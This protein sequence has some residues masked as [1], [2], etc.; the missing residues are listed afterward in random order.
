MA[1]NLLHSSWTDLDQV[2]LRILLR[3][4]IGQPGQF[5]GNTDVLYL[6][7]AREKCRVSLTYKGSRII[8]IEPGEAFDRPEWDRICAEIET[9]ILSG[10]RKVG[11]E[12]SFNTFR[13]GGS[14]RGARSGV[15]ILPPPDQAPQTPMEITDHPF[16]LEFPIQEAGLWSI[17][18]H[19][20][21]REHRKLTLLLN[22]LLVGTTKFLPERPR[23]LWACVGFG[24]E[25]EIKWVQEWYF[26]KLSEAI[27]NEL[28]P[29]T[30]E[31]LEE[32]SH[33]SNPRPR[34]SGSLKPRKRIAVGLTK[35][36]TNSTPLRM[37]WKTTRTFT[38]ASWETPSRPPSA[39]YA[40]TLQFRS[41]RSSPRRGASR[42]SKVSV[43]NSG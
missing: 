37:I 2:D 20:R 18:N 33:R 35:K 13:V 12:Y 32:L 7:L 4:R 14:W 25:P 36:R 11:R 22:L 28:S 15:Q 8:A 23:H 10:P 29:P 34:R 30:I 40:R 1:E 3:D 41:I 16:I 38:S 19:R 6:P 17:S 27:A 24:S 31:K 5:D 26:A 21:I 43:M 39:F 42:S 9:S